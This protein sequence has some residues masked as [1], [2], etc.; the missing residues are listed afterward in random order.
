MRICDIQTEPV[1]PTKLAKPRPPWF[2][3]WYVPHFHYGDIN[4]DILQ[5]KSDE[6][7]EDVHLW[8]RHFD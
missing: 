4:I 6:N 1:V 8:V 7:N 2:T 5:I 3:R